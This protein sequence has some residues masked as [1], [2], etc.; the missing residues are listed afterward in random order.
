MARPL[1][2]LRAPGEPTEEKECLKAMTEPPD[3]LPPYRLLTGPD[4]DQFC[5]RVSEALA[6]GYELYGSP[7]V[8]H[9][10]KE[11]IC[12]QA[13]CWPSLPASPTKGGVG[14]RGAS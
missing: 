8:T 5:K 14:F 4:D 1:A 9:N 13:V 3:G 12:A 11:V 7:S 10:G 6:A 2:L